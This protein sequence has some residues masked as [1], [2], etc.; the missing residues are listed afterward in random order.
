MIHQITI[1]LHTL[2]SSSDSPH[3]TPES[4]QSLMLLCSV[5]T[6]SHTW[7][8][9]APFN[10]VDGDQSHVYHSHHDPYSVTI[11]VVLCVALS[12][13]LVP[14]TDAAHSIT[15]ISELL[16]KR[17][18]AIRYRPVP[19]TLGVVK[20]AEGFCESWNL[21]CIS[22]RSALSMSTCIFNI[23]MWSSK[24]FVSSHF[25]WWT[26]P[27]KQ[28][29]HTALCEQGAMESGLSIVSGSGRSTSHDWSSWSGSEYFT[30][31]VWRIGSK[32]SLSCWKVG[33]STQVSS[34]NLSY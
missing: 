11:S 16:L 13:Q 15:R 10:N 22:V 31:L 29:S 4:S 23:F 19:S 18:A 26:W 5:H 1:C 8:S 21:S 7:L 2:P 34:G 30:G 9:F 28:Q 20:N 27:G 12:R 3:E 25:K 14:I 17:F 33:E 6:L 24:C 32:V